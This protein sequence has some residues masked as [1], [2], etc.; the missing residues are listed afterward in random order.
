MY[1]SL[2]EKW[3]F[4]K[5]YS[6]NYI[7]KT[8]RGPSMTGILHKETYSQKFQLIS[9]KYVFFYSHWII[10]A[11]SSR[12]PL[13][14]LLY[15]ILHCLICPHSHH[16]ADVAS[17]HK[18][19]SQLKSSS[20]TSQLQLPNSDNPSPSTH[21]VGIYHIIIIVWVPGYHSVLTAHPWRETMSHSSLFPNT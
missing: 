21:N 16:G 4:S 12:V 2:L 15:T 20:T 9:H 5:C 8:E 10:Y 6:I 13:N 19:S 11:I 1:M 3:V 18:V 14:F 17:P 7:S